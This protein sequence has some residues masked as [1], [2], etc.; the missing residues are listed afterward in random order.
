MST[1]IIIVIITK[2]V[3]AIRVIARATATIAIHHSRVLVA[4]DSPLISRVPFSYWLASIQEYLIN[5]IGTSFS[6]QHLNRKLMH[7]RVHFLQ[8]EL[9]LLIEHLLRL[10]MRSSLLLSNSMNSYSSIL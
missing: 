7:R 2:S 6:D 10:Q 5:S 8:K 3:I 4:Q 1:I 9:P